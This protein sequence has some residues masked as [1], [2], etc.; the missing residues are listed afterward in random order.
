MGA[1]AKC[2]WVCPPPR[3]SRG[4]Q[5]RATAQET[6]KMLS[7]VPSPQSFLLVIHPLPH[8]R[9][10][11]FEFFYFPS[12]LLS[13]TV[14][15]AGAARRGFEWLASFHG[16][17]KTRLS[18]AHLSLSV[19]SFSVL[20]SGMSVKNSH[21]GLPRLGVCPPGRSVVPGPVV[22]TTTLVSSRN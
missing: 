12:F 1:P 17:A 6:G 22:A 3:G 11:F 18:L 16:F 13:Q 8:S 21:E 2:F 10:V 7:M 19:T 14:G 5:G 20:G 4:A 15:V 9:L